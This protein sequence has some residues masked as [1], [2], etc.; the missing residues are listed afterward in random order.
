LTNRGPLFCTRRRILCARTEVYSGLYRGRVLAAIGISKEARKVSA[1]RAVTTKIFPRVAMFVYFL[2]KQKMNNF[3][4]QFVRHLLETEKRKVVDVVYELK[5][6]RLAQGL[7][8]YGLSK[9][10]VEAFMK[11][12]NIGQHRL[13]DDEVEAAVKHSIQLVGNMV[14]GRMIMGKHRV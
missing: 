14:G 3:S 10:S 2:D 11:K 6:I 8:D 13:N 12:H 1:Q 7:D 4:P 9:R 5:R